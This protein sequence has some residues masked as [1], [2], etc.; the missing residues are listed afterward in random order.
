MNRSATIAMDAEAL[1]PLLDAIR[2][3][4]RPLLPQGRVADYIPRLAT[5]PADR[6][7][8][9]VATLDGGLACCG[10]ADTRFS[11]QSISKVY[12]L[13][14]ALNAI[15][16]ALWKRVGREP[17]GNAFN[18]LVQLEYENGI[19]RNPLINAGAH[20]VADVVLSNHR[21]PRGLL[22]DF[23]RR[24]A[25]DPGVF[26]DAEVARSEALHGDRNAALAH[27]I[28]SFGNLDN[29]VAEVL[30]FYY[31]QCSLAMSCV[32]LARGFLFLANGGTCPVS[33]E[34]VCSPER[35][36]RIN[37]VMLSCGTYDAAGDFAFRVGLPAK[38][39]V[40]GG[41]VAVVPGRMA[42]AVWS[43]GLDARGNSL[44][45][46]AALERFTSATGLSVF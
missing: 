22:L 16:D 4:V 29:P 15:G 21:D 23:A 33:G 1:A 27:F 9:A 45:G 39:G 7:G 36:R 37:A 28:R 25:G 19:P 14:L 17:S 13:T 12:T 40:G 34:R 46:M 3:D 5:V 2:A 26:D 44:A 8:M 20:V 43:P 11:I 30:A 18:S 35:A 24:R 10:D 31:F 32:D 38:S 41:I 42:I 6:F